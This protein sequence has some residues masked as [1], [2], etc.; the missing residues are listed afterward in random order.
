[1]RHDLGPTAET[2]PVEWRAIVCGLLTHS[3]GFAG[4][5]GSALRIDFESPCIISQR[6]AEGLLVSGT[7]LISGDYPHLHLLRCGVEGL[8]QPAAHC[9]PR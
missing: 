7:Y 1:M 9:P 4:Q 6:V 8:A 3:V 5:L 2:R